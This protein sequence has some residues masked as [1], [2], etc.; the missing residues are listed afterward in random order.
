MRW[1][2]PFETVA[3]ALSYAK[4]VARSN[5]AGVHA[6]VQ[7][8]LNDTTQSLPT[9]PG[10]ESRD[11]GASIWLGKNDIWVA[12]TPATFAT[13]REQEW[14]DEL[15]SALRSVEPEK[16]LSG[17]IMEFA[18][19]T[20]SPR[21]VPRDLDNLCE[22][23]FSLIVN[24]LKWFEGSRPNIRW[25]AASMAVAESTG[26][27]IRASHASGFTAPTPQPAFSFSFAGP[28]PRRGT[29]PALPD[30]LAGRIHESAPG[31]WLELQLLFGGRSVNIGDICTGRVKNV[32]DCL[33]PLIGG[34][35][36]R[37]HDHRIRRL[38]VAKGSNTAPA[39]GV[40]IN[41]WPH[42]S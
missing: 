39:N 28:L 19:D 42:G 33:Y 7:G 10:T 1:R 36:G 21:G 37:P 20:L 18:I 30:A 14:K 9:A 17:L 22:P 11:L 5:P 31:E 24:T 26:L 6:C 35:P 15:N 41:L 29:D 38:H 3:D 2:G 40:L 27:R 23:V 34:T 13:R 4:Q 12:G 16:S 32:I 25:W 8:D